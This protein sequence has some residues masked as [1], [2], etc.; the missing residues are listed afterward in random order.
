MAVENVEHFSPLFILI[1][2][3]LKF[4]TGKNIHLVVTTQI[5]VNKLKT[6]FQQKIPINLKKV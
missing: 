4:V 3:V 2:C 5:Y 1:D 6:F